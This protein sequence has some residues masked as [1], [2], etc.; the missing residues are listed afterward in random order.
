[1]TEIN[2]K[3]IIQDDIADILNISDVEMDAQI[4]S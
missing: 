3:I 2:A 1:M 4:E